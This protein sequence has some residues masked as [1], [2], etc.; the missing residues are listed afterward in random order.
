MSIVRCLLASQSSPP[1]RR[2]AESSSLPSS[3]PTTSAAGSSNGNRSGDE[4]DDAVEDDTLVRSE[5]ETYDPNE[6]PVDDEE[7]EDGED[8]LE[9]AERDYRE[10]PALDTYDAGDLDETDYAAMDPTARAAAEL[11][12][13][14]RD[15][16]RAQGRVPAAF[17]DD[18]ESEDEAAAG[19]L[20]RRRRVAAGRDADAMD[21]DERAI[22]EAPVD[23]LED[24]KGHS[25]RE[26]VTLTNTR[27]AIKNQ[28]RHFLQTYLDNEGQPVYAMRIRAMCERT[29]T[30]LCVF[31]V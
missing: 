1:R 6:I 24:M 9:G 21:L 16:A 31:L 28:F 20:R 26:W 25:L 5:D 14:K 30:Y 17:M 2:F 18:E 8:L 23:N 13:R 27:N 12:M 11:R 4:D 3:P 10:M 22:Q 15:R 19:R 7:A 29:L